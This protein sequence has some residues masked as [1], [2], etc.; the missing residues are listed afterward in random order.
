MRFIATLA[1]YEAYRAYLAGGLLYFCRSLATT[2][3]D[4]HL[5]ARAKRLGRLGFASWKAAMGAL[6]ARPD[7]SQVAEFIR[8]YGAA[9][10][11]GLRS[12]RIKARLRQAATAFRPA[13]YLG[14]DPRME[15]PP[16]DL[17]D[18][19]VCGLWNGRG[20]RVCAESSCREP[21]GRMTRYRTWSFALTSAYCGERYGIPLGARYRD[22]IRWLPVMRP[23][24]VRA[25]AAAREFYDAVYAVTH[26]VYTL[27]D[28]GRYLLS[29]WW[30]PWEYEFLRASLD[31]ALAM[32][33]PDMVGEFLDTLRAFEVGDDDD[34]VQRGFDFLLDTQNSDGSWGAWDAASLYTGFHATWAAIDGLREFTWTGPRLLFPE[35]LPSLRRWAGLRG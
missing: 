11:L 7:A 27:N 2:A 35:L 16:S 20:R 34:Q 12:P 25:R 23:Y 13:D 30:L 26:V 29:P 10:T 32:N 6:P 17:P 21:L 5:A 33:D 8:A 4:R 3:A 22:A 9:D 19:C 18:T 15:P 31:I 28:Y 1:R 24:P 14:F